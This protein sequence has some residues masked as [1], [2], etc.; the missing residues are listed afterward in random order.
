MKKLILLTLLIVLINRV[1]AQT[2]SEVIK[3][4]FA[5]EK[6]GTEKTVFVSNI[7]G[8]IRVQG[9][10]GSNVLLE[11]T[12]EVTAKTETRLEQGKK[13]IQLGVIDRADTLVFY[14]ANAC[15]T[16]GKINSK[17]ARNFGSRHPWGYNWEGNHHCQPPYDYKLDFVLKVPYSVN[18][19]LST[20][21]EGDIV[22]KNVLGALIVDNI[23][24][25]IKLTN[26]SRE[27]TASTINGNVDIEYSKNPDKACR[28]YT[29]NGDINAWFQKGLKATMSFKSFQGEFFT[30]VPA[31]E[32]LPIQVVKED[33][34]KGTRYS[35]NSNRFK[36][37]SGG[38]LLDFET[39]NGNVYLKEV[40]NN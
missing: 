29:L 30:N 3:K 7:N 25:A 12:R 1:M 32:S 24:G 5:F 16:F 14:M 26:I 17:R 31:L 9:Y 34:A 11:V 6:V 19:V 13:E 33:G 18:L 39:F 2:F 35:V 21:N 10:D 22:V 27:A 4:E 23:N 40:N 37:G 38:A 8:N 20:V 28:F 15:H 36:I